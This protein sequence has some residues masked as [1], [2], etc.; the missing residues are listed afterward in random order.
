MPVFSNYRGILP[1]HPAFR[2]IALSEPPVIAS[3]TQQWLNSELLTMFFYHHMRSLS[4]EEEMQVLKQLVSII[5]LFS[6]DVVAQYSN[7][8]VMFYSNSS[9]ILGSRIIKYSTNYGFNS[10]TQEL[11]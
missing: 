3:S 10:E 8:L 2:I 5:Y 9:S 11:R 6:R 4:Q 1:I 7:K